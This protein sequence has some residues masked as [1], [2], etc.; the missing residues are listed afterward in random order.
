MSILFKM[1]CQSGEAPVAG[2]KENVVPIFKKSRK[3]DPG[4]YWACS[5]TSEAWKIMEQMSLNA[6]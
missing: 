6:P 5:L 1:S 3:E 4:D 2:K